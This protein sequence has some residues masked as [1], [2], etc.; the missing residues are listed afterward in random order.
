MKQES[1]TSLILGIVGI[2]IEVISFFIFGWLS[3]VGLILG[4]IGVCLPAPT[5]GDKVPAIISIVLGI[6]C[7]IL[8]IIAIVNIR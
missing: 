4:T 3:I 8:W 6:V 2:G 1:K 5:K 7:V